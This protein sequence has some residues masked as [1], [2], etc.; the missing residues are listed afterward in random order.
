M[1][2]YELKQIADYVRKCEQTLDD[3]EFDNT[4]MQNELAPLYNVIMKLM[5]ASEK[6]GDSDERTLY[7]AVEYKARICRN[8]IIEHTGIRN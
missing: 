5:K 8:K 4:A 3:N 7:A 1:T 6:S 2:R